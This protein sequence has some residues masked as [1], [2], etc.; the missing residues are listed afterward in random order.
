MA[1]LA[2]I[3]GGRV[4]R[5]LARGNYA[6]VAGAAA[7]QHLRVIHPPHRRPAHQAMTVLTLGSRTNVIERRRRGPD[8]AAATVARGTFKGRPLEDAR[9]VAAFA[10]HIAMR[11]FEWPGGG[12][13]IK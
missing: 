6:V 4:I 10:I 8:Q 12:E 11:S 9:D 13:M 1:Q 3:G 7:A 5:R 2:L